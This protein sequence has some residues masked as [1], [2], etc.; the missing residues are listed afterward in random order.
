MKQGIL[1]AGGLGTRLGPV[2]NATN[3]HFLPIY[4]KPLIY[5]PLSTMILAGVRKIVVICTPESRQSY[6][7]LL[8]NG[9]SFGIE[10]LYAEQIKP[11][12]IPQAFV[13]AERFLDS[14]KGVFLALGDN[15][16]Y[17][18][19]TG[20]DMAEHVFDA[21]ARVF[22]YPVSNPENFGVVEKTNDGEI[23]SIEEK[24]IAPKSNLAIIG[25]YEF[26]ASAFKF[27]TQL[28][29]SQ[30]GEYEIVDLI[31]IYRDKGQLEVTE[32]PRGSAWLDAGTTEGFMESSQFVRALQKRQ[33]LLVGSPHEAAWRTGNITESKLLEISKRFGSSE[34]GILLKQTIINEKT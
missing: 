16:I 25:F 11:E 22:C 32:L 23:L 4:D 13:L 9:D 2:T 26:P 12:G 28:S 17:G 21:N 7:E 14:N 15:V 1:L 31:R 5:Y 19:G 33:G 24:P 18:P 3:K 34:Y 6:Q 30:R 8:G 29:K 20:R 27:V 10:I